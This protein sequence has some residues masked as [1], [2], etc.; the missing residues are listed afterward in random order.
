M[1]R[2]SGLRSATMRSAASKS[3][4]KVFS[5]AATASQSTA[6]QRM[7]FFLTLAL[8]SSSLQASQIDYEIWPP[9]FMI[10]V[11]SFTSTV[12]ASHQ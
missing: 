7:A 4:P 6:T 10:V 8:L 5:L 3:G 9:Q 2:P 12:L 1:M 11:A